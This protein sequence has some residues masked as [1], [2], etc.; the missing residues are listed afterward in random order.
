MLNKEKVQRREDEKAGE[1]V[2]KNQ[3]YGKKLGE[4]GEI[5]LDL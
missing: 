5:F 1:L 4:G 3:Q 2:R